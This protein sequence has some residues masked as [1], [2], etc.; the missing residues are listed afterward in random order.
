[1]SAMD[2]DMDMDMDMENT[3][4]PV[5]HAQVTGIIN[6]IDNDTR[7][8]NISRGAIEKW[9]RPAATLDFYIANN[10]ALAQ[11]STGME[12]DFTFAI[13]NGEFTVI[14]LHDETHADA[15]NSH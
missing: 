14:T 9:Q 8:A 4:Q 11:L 13:E 5:A 7:I 3:S 2:M 6:S 10:I 15:D 12:I 1:M